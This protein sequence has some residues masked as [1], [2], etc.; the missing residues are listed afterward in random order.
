MALI[1]EALAILVGGLVLARLL[2][3]F[4]PS[5]KRFPIAGVGVVVAL[6]AGV[7]F[8]YHAY[9]IASKLPESTA[10]ASEVSS[11]DAQHEGDTSANNAFLAW[12]RKQMLADTHGRGTYYLTP[13][14]VSEE[15]ELYQ[16]ST[17][18]LLPERATPKLREAD[19]IVFYGAKR[20]SALE[21]RG[22]W[23]ISQFASGY[24]LARRS[25]AR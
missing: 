19:W 5:L 1:L 15:P 9:R 25:N 3:S 11:F 2:V 18:E 7:L 4:S 16:W 12:A 23:T 17:Y 21:Q 14:S 10:T 22:K 13:A 8:W 20:V 24:M 6:G